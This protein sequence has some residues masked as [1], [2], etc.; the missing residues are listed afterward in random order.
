MTE[1]V[2]SNIY[3]I[4]GQKVMLSSSDGKS[5]YTKEVMNV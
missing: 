2:E 5:L 4:R 3:M 1:P